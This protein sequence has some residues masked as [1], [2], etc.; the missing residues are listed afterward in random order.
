MN[1]KKV[2]PNK[3][4]AGASRDKEWVLSL[5]GEAELERLV[6]AGVLPDHVTARWRL[7]SGEPF[8]M[9]NTDEV[10]VFEDYF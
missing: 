6:E 9:P 8:P 1:P 4:G 5:T 7:A 3:V 2:S 10:V